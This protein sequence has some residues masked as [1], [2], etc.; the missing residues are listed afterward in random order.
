MWPKWYCMSLQMLKEGLI[1]N[2]APE[3]M[4]HIF[5]RAYTIATSI[6]KAFSSNTELNIEE[7]ND[8]LLMRDNGPL[9]AS[10]SL[11]LF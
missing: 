3:L 4:S 1:E 7:Q 6:G 9:V 10:P 11:I 5:C 2:D 8:G